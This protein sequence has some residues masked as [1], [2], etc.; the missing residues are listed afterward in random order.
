ML[1]N[2]VS[3]AQTTDIEFDEV[4]VNGDLAPPEFCQGDVPIFQLRFRLSSGSTTLT[5]TSTNTLEIT[6]E[7]SGANILSKTVT[8][9]TILG[10]GSSIINSQESDYYT[11]PIVGADAIQLANAGSTDVQFKIVINSSAFTDPTETATTVTIITNA[12][13]SKS[14][15]S[16]S[17]IL[18]IYFTKALKELP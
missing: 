7:G 9:I 3:Y 6:A 10:D 4:T 11:W 17:F 8:N 18:S 2:S 13:P 14:N 16:S 15:I 1:Y 5:L 12:N